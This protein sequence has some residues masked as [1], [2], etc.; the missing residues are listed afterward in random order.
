MRLNETCDIKDESVRYAPAYIPG[1]S[2][3]ALQA[4]CLVSIQNIR[5]YLYFNMTIGMNLCD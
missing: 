2:D 1:V 4:Q 5:E 3:L